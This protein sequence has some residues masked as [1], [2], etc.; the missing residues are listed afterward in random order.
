MNSRSGNRSEFPVRPP[1]PL[2][3][4]EVKP[5]SQIARSL[6]SLIR[7]S[8]QGVGMARTA[9]LIIADCRNHDWAAI[10]ALDL[11][12]SQLADLSNSACTCRPMGSAAFNGR[13]ETQ[14]GRI[15]RP[16][17]RDPKS[18]SS[19]SAA[20]Y[21]MTNSKKSTRGQR[22]VPETLQNS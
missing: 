1:L 4:H 9:R 10:L 6:R 12:V 11:T 19:P 17:E 3:L 22:W 20:G 18:A 15:L 21:L 14:T 7:R 13:L 2:R 16:F 5:S 8:D